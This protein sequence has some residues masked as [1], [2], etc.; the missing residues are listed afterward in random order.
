MHQ[1]SVVSGMV[2]ALEICSHITTSISRIQKVVRIFN[3]GVCLLVEQ[4][5]NCVGDGLWHKL[6][7]MLTL[8]IMRIVEASILSEIPINLLNLGNFPA[9]MFLSHLT[10]HSII[11]SSS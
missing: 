2:S 4:L 9:V 3:L 5:L 8:D 6:Q 11:L 7:S 1:L 10:R